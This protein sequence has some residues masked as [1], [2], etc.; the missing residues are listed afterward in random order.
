VIILKTL[1]ESNKSPFYLWLN[2]EEVIRYSLSLFQKLN[3]REEIDIWFSELLKDKSIKLGIYSD[4]IFVGYAGIC[5]ISLANNSGEYFIFIGDKNY[6][7]KGCG[8]TVSRQIIDIGFEKY[9]LNRIMLTVSEPNIAGIKA[10]E[11]AGFKYEG[12][13]KQACMRDGKYHDKIIMAVLRE[14]WEN[15]NQN[16]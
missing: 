6:W 16:E 10:Y 12:R 5:N 15:R 13:Q 11:K 8:T 1:K 3:K 9:N 4:N 2:D 14:E 7:S